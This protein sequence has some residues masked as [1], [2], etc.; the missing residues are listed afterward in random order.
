MGIHTLHG[1]GLCGGWSGHW[2]AIMAV[3][4]P[5]NAEVHR[6]AFTRHLRQKFDEL[7]MGF[8]DVFFAQVKISTINTILTSIFLLGIL[9]ALGHPL[10]MAWIWWW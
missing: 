8:N 6:T 3:Q 10:P 2:R 1:Y 9:P 5:V 4:L 7:I